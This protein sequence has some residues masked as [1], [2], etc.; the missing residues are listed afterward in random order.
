MIRVGMTWSSTWTMLGAPDVWKLAF[1]LLRHNNTATRYG[2]RKCHE[3]CG[4][5]SDMMSQGCACVRV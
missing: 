3:L 1:K 2:E 4:C 5:Y